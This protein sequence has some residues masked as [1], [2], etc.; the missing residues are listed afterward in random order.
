MLLPL[1]HLSMLGRVTRSEEKQVEDWEV[2][3][4]ARR[5][6]EDE[7]ETDELHSK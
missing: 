4:V 6:R 1:D 7:I 5:L 2:L 3:E